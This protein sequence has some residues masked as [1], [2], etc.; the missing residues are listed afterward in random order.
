MS[1]D[2]PYITHRQALAGIP[3]AVTI[4]SLILAGVGQ[5]S[6]RRAE[7]AADRAE[8]AASQVAERVMAMGAANKIDVSQ[9]MTGMEG[10]LSEQVRQYSE[11]VNDL[12]KMLLRGEVKPVGGKR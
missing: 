7:A 9:Q 11:Q 5:C 1:L 12:T 6:V 2:S 4:G 10:R 3:V 8:G